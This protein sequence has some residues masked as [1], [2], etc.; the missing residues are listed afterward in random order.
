MQHVLRQQRGQQ[1]ATYLV[2]DPQRAADCRTWHHVSSSLHQSRASTHHLK[3]DN[4]VIR[5]YIDVI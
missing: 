2:A 1:P 3:G 4:Y 5:I